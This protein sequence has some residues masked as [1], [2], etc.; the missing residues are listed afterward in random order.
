MG[1]TTKNGLLRTIDQS[2]DPV[3]YATFTNPALGALQPFSQT[4]VQ[5]IDSLDAL[6]VQYQHPPVALAV[7]MGPKTR[8]VV[9]A[10][11]T[12]SID[13]ELAN[14]RVS[15]IN[16]LK[17]PGS[18]SVHLLKNGKVIAS[19]GFFQ[20]TEVEKCETCV[21]NAIAHFDFELPVRDASGGQ[22][23]VWVEPV[24]KSF[25]GDHFPAKLMGEPT[26][27]AHLLLS[28]G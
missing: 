17:I 25:V 9:P 11:D 28:S 14:V 12:F 1:A 19:R 26:V 20:P 15:G 3:S 18:F 4:A 27:D 13:S 21:D 16:R 5:T 8:P 2:K 7:T 23:E 6:H 10:S 22:F 24:D